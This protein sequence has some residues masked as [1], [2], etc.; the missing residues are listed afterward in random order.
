MDSYPFIFQQFE[1]KIKSKNIKKLIL[2]LILNILSRTTVLSNF[3][4]FQPQIFMKFHSRIRDER[5]R[6][7]VR[8]QALFCSRTRTRTEQEQKK[9]CSLF[10]FWTEWCT[11]RTKQCLD[12]WLPLLDRSLSIIRDWP[13]M[14]PIKCYFI[15]IT[16]TFLSTDPVLRSMFSILPFIFP[17]IGTSSSSGAMQVIKLE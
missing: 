10:F 7:H 1:I 2:E 9:S 14:W 13:A 8:E 17:V 4:K 12:P 11:A 16:N 6:E 3:V 5:E 15:R